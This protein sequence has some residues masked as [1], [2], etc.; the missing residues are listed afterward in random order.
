MYAKFVFVQSRVFNEASPIIG[1]P[2]FSIS[3]VPVS[4]VADSLPSP[5][6]GIGTPD[7]SVTEN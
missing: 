7:V 4:Q 6:R 3:D 2:S 5:K 1:R